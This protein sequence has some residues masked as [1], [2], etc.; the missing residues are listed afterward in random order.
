[1]SRLLVHVGTGTILDLDDGCV[2]INL[3]DSLVDADEDEIVE[4]ADTHGRPVNTSV[5]DD[6]T[7]GNIVCYSPS[8]L[9]EEA[10][11][12]I[13]DI[14]DEYTK[15]ALQFVISKATDKDLYDMAGF[16]LNGETIWTTFREDIIEASRQ[17][18]EW[19][20]E[21]K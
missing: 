10:R 6:V 8:S 4:Y 21:Q 14:T 15:E 5:H 11:E 12:I 7:Y 1:M 9:R 19:S 13:H 3:P 16:I 2:F 18:L 17:A 20:K